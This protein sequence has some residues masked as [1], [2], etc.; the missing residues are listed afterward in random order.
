MQK[1]RIAFIL[2]VF[3]V[4]GVASLLSSLPFGRKFNQDV[5]ASIPQAQVS[6]IGDS[7]DTMDAATRSRFN[8]QTAL[9]RNTVVSLQE[10]APGAASSTR[11]A[12]FAQRAQRVQGIAKIMFVTNQPLLRLENFK[13]DNGPDLYLYLSPALN[14]SDVI[15]LG[16]L[17]A[18]EGNVNYAIPAGTDTRKYDKVLIWSREYGVLFS[19]AEFR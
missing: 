3:G 7:L 6:T 8:L 13:T 5:G 1:S 9:L 16:P 17:R 12:E 18:T 10:P 15:D 11:Q 4:F 14:N 2:V 19:Y